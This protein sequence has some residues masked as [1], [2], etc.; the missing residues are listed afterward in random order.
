MSLFVEDRWEIFLIMTVI[1]GGGAAF[2]AGRALARG[3][4]P[5]WVPMLYMVP[6]GLALRFLHFALF[7]TQLTSLHYF[8]S[9]T[10]ILLAASLIGYRMTRTDQM[11]DQY[12]WLYEK[13][14]PFTWRSK[15]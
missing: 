3:W 1:M 4:K 15:A 8:I 5:I 11:A 10:L 7:G 12:P 6:L 9:D 2:M 14:G 13:T